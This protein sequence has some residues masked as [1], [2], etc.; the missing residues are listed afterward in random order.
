[1]YTPRPASPP[2]RVT[3]ELRRK[4]VFRDL[5]RILCTALDKQTS[6]V[7]SQSVDCNRRVC[8]TKSDKYTG[9]WAVGSSSP[10][11]RGPLR[12][13]FIAAPPR[14]DCKIRSERKIAQ[15]Q[16]SLLARGC[17]AELSQVKT[18]SRPS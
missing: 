17:I 2:R 9:G 12:L 1:M 8:R 16:A 15:R 3:L 11:S 14:L 7:E 5:I 18:R 4:G 10:T 6:T 13:Y